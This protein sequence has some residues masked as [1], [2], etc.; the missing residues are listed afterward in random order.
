MELAFDK[1]L[2][3]KVLIIYILVRTPLVENHIHIG[4]EYHYVLSTALFERLSH[5]LCKCCIM[6]AA[7]KKLLSPAV[8]LSEIEDSLKL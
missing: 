8:L 3:P 2:D 7:T 4:S 1:E 6:R 5:R